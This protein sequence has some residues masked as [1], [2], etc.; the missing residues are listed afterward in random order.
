MDDID[1][2]N[3]KMVE[4]WVLDRPRVRTESFNKLVDELKGNTLMAEIMWVYWGEG[5][6]GC[7]DSVAPYLNHHLRWWKFGQEKNTIRK[8]IKTAEG[9]AWVWQMLNEAGAWL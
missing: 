7:L 8:L 5:S 1:E 6:I 3:R 4:A 2:A 9:K